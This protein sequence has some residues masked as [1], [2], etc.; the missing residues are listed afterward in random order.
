MNY[1]KELTRTWI[2]D[3]GRLNQDLHSKSKSAKYCSDQYL[4]T[5]GLLMS[6]LSLSHILFQHENFGKALVKMKSDK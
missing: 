3:L 5:I 1:A 2:F 6:F 4:T